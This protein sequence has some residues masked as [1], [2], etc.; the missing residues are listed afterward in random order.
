MNIGPLR[1]RPLWILVGLGA[2]AMLLAVVALRDVASRIDAA[3]RRT[4]TP[5]VEEPSSRFSSAFSPGPKLGDLRDLIAG[6]EPRPDPEELEALE[7]DTGS[8]PDPEE[9]PEDEPADPG[10]GGDSGPRLRT[11]RAPRLPGGSR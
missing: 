7:R 2:L 9:E 4:P 10:D 6:I 8:T 11:P 5:R 1:V 3:E